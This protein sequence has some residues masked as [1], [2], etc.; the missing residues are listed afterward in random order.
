M[1]KSFDVKLIGFYGW[2]AVAYF[3]LAI[4]TT[5]GKYPNQFIA[6]VFNNAWAVPYVTVLNFILF[7][8]TVP[9]VVRQRKMV[10]L[11]VLLG[12][13]LLFFYMILYS[14]G[15]YLWRSLGIQ[16]H[17]Y[18]S[19]RVFPSLGKLLENQMAYSVG[20]IFLFGITRHSYNYIKLK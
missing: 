12:A 4:L 10:V 18:R 20:S 8:Y 5:V 6:V 1:K 14:Y 15:S 3:L 9:F 13:L 2:V 17:V 11:T 19:L 7:E 16:L